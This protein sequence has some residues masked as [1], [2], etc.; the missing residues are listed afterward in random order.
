M[1]DCKAVICGYYGRDNSGDE[2]LLLSLLQ[3]LPPQVEPIVLSAN[4]EQTQKRY[5]VTACP[6]RSLSDILRVFR[7]S[8]YFIWGGGSLMQDV[9]SIASPIYYAGLMGLAQLMGLQTI[10]WAQGIGPLNRSLSRWLTKKVLRGCKAISVRDYGSANLL[11]KWKISPVIAPDP[12]WALNSNPL[13]HLCD[14]PAPRVAV[15][16]RSHH[17]LTPQKLAI[18]GKALAEFQ[19]ATDAFL[20]LVPFQP[21]QDGAIADTLATYLDDR[22]QIL[23]SNDPRELKGLFRG[24]EM[25]I[26]MRFHSLIMAAAEGC[27]CFAISY[28]PKVSQL[29]QEV[30]LVGWELAEMPDNAQEM[31]KNWIEYYANGESVCVDRLQSLVDRAFMHRDLLNF[32]RS[33]DE[34]RF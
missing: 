6:N 12:V 10:A 11:S 30:D 8:Q 27:R 20:L 24:V 9:T 2:A 1:N 4:P 25:T 14:L 7:Q 5:G 17:L 18:I 28:D 31:S 15:C 33:R 3:M 26:G 29:M 34:K 22:Y 32:M 21:I 23:T 13:P 16:L 19:Q